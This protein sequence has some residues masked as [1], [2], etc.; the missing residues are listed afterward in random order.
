MARPLRIERAG[1]W[2]HLTSRGND[3]KAIFRQDADRRHFLEL[4]AELVAR[5][6]VRLH[7]YVLMDNHYHLLLELTEPN[8][9]RAM[10]WLTLSYSMWFNRRHQRTGH[11]FQ[12]R[13]KSVAVDR[14][15]W[16][17]ELSRY[18][19][20]NPVRT[21]AMGL[22]KGQRSAQRQ[23]LGPAPD[24]R[25]VAARLARLRGHRW[26][27][28][29]AY[30]GWAPVPPW[31]ECGAVLGLGGGRKAEQ[32]KAYRLYVETA[33]REGLKRT[34]WE[35]VREQ[36]VLGGREFLAQLR[37]RIKGDAQEQR[38]ARRLASERPDLAAVIRAVERVKG[39]NWDA[40][41]ERH[42][43]RGRDLVLYLGRRACGLKLRELAAAVGLRNHAVVATNASRYAKTL[44]EDRREQ[45]TLRRVLELLNCNI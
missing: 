12:G 41:R 4:L 2:Y 44:A 43:D 42:G 39:E 27:S 30:V 22:G 14:D 37:E 32:R 35:A 29:P 9:S 16:A 8:L 40:F 6:R 5:F 21:T 34:P 17:L 20:L 7:S 1:G 26:S 10:Q 23:G 15:E 33:V 11:L 36:V 25:L 31:L 45:A 38:A 19:H 3:R 13:F 28:Y 18:V 24:A